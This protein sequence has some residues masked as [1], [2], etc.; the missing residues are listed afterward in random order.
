VLRRSP[1]LVLDEATISL[2]SE[3]ES[4]I[5]EALGVLMADRTA[6]VVA[7]RLSTVQAMDRLVVLAAGEIREDGSPAPGGRQHLHQPL[8]AAVRQSG[9]F[10]GNP[11]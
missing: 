8:E 7:H 2:D 10:L 3:S 1:I 6:I 11:A 9:G 5:Q 4:L